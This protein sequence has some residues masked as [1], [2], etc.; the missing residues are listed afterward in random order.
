M[1]SQGETTSTK[2][3]PKM[4]ESN[5]DEEDLVQTDGEWEV[6]GKQRKANNLSTAT[7][8]RSN[9]QRRS[10]QAN[11]AQGKSK[12]KTT[13]PHSESVD[14]V[15]EDKRQLSEG[16]TQPVTPVVSNPWAKVPSV[17]PVSITEA[18]QEETPSPIKLTGPYVLNKIEPIPTQQSNA[19]LDSSDWPTLSIIETVNKNLKFY[20]KKVP[21]MCDKMKKTL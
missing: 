7:T 6:A 21:N 1:S 17:T 20:L 13:E 15:D 16:E 12:A 11:R 8:P 4:Q 14:K 5:D 2:E 10:S 3:L 19:N 18:K 9:K